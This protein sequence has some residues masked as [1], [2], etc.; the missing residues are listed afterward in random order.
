MTNRNPRGA[1]KD[2]I[3]L[4]LEHLSAD[5]LDERLPGIIETARIFAGVDAHKEP[6]PVVPT[7]HYIMG[8]IPTTIKA[9]VVCPTED[10]RPQAHPRNGRGLAQEDEFPEVDTAA[11]PVS[12][13]GDLW[14][15][16]E[17]VQKKIDLAHLEANDLEIDL[18]CKFQN[19]GEFEGELLA[20]AYGIV[21]YPVKRKPQH[22][23]LGLGQVRES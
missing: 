15:L 13:P 20:L 12:R 16:G 22:P 7:V 11:A 19:L 6:I 1:K 2:H 18:R 10:H 4:H 21:G 17:H 8:G 23:Q 14:L 5:L 9:E 3:Y